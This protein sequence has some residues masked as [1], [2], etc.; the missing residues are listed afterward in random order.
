MLRDCKLKLGIQAPL[1][2]PDRSSD[3]HECARRN[4]ERRQ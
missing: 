4:D 3:R 2:A 1:A